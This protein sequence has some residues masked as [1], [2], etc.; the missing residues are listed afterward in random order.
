MQYDPIYD[1]PAIKPL[2][3]SAALEAGRLLEHDPKRGQMGFCYV[4]WATIK[5]ILREEHGI[6]WKTP[7]E[8]NPDVLFD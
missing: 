4:T 3:D 8:M 7:S 5:R 1:D 6:E 2:I